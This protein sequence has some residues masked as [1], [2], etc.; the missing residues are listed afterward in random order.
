MTDELAQEVLRRLPLA[1][2]TLRVWRW[3]A[4]DEVLADLFTEHRGRAYERVISFQMLT[5]LMAEALVH[6][7]G[8]A[9]RCFEEAV[10]DGSLPASVQAV[11]GKVRRMP[12]EVSEAL[13]HHATVRLHEIWPEGMPSRCPPSLD[14]FAH[15]LVLDGKTIKRVTRR[16]KPLRGV[17]AGLLGGRAVTALSLR[18]GVVEAMNADPDG[19]AGEVALAPELVQ[20]LR[21][22][23]PSSRRLWVCDRGFCTQALLEL[24]SRDD[25]AY[26]LRMHRNLR[27]T[28]DPSIPAQHGVDERGRRYEESW[29]WVG[30][31]RQP[32]RFVV[33]QITL[34]RKSAEKDG[35]DEIVLITNLGDAHQHPA[36]DL[37]QV[38]LDR[39]S[40]ERVF[41]EVTEVFGLN[42]L[43]GSTPQA[44]IFQFSF[45]LLLYNIIQ[46]HRAY[47]AQGQRREVVSISSEKLFQDVR[48][49]LIAW[50]RLIGTDATPALIDTIDHPDAVRRRLQHLLHPRWKPRWAKAPPR[51]HRPPKPRRGQSYR[52]HQS[53]HRILQH[54]KQ[55]A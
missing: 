32:E 48:D 39:W 22:R 40:I 27:F 14:A 31:T 44:T 8:H 34:L 10:A 43:I 47:I 17:R 20:T 15:V 1:E 33:R 36:V 55:Q 26:L 29:G 50:S 51:P 5:Q 53:V 30:T 45:C 28:Q 52:Q 42:H 38:Y 54:H 4:H 7:Q 21:S 9:R 16:L 37:L 19:H 13:L 3:M 12:I 18:R 25:D 24:F 2:A 11:Y 49:D 23:A 6:H 41:Q 35:A 46:L